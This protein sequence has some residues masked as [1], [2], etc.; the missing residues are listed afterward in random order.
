MNLVAR[1]QPNFLVILTDDLGF[2]DLGCYGS[3]IETPHLDKLA[4]NGV[5][6]SQFYNTAKCHSSR[7]ALLSGRWCAQAGDI[8]LNRAVTIAEVLK[9]NNYFTAMSGKWHLAGKPEDFGFQHYY[10]HLSGSSDYFKGNNTFR[11]NAK[12]W[13]IPKKGFYTTIYKVNY[14]L[15]FLQEARKEKKPWFLYLAFNAPHGPLQPLKEDY[16]KYLKRYDEGWD[17]IRDRRMAKQKKLKLFAKSLEPSARPSH[18][19]SWVDMNTLEKK[20]EKMRMA[21]Y[22]GM[23]DRVDQELGRVF[24]DLE[25]KKELQNTVIIFMSDNGACPYDRRPPE[26]DSVPYDGTRWSDS[27]GW[28]WAR[29]APFRFYK[30]NQFEGG[31]SSPCIVHWPAGLK[32]QQGS[33]NHTPTHLVD[34][35]PTIADIAGVNI[36]SEWPGRDVSPLAGVSLKPVLE[37]K[38]L[39]RR[40][41]IHLKF[42]KDVGLR[43]GDWKLV[44]FQGQSWELYNIKEDRTELKNLSAQYPERVQAMADMWIQMSEKDLK[45]TNFVRPAI[46]GEKIPKT[47]RGWT[48][49][50]KSSAKKSSQ[51]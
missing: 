20:W 24:K 26:P 31:I 44:S 22:A 6:F 50:K 45:I 27:T 5:R 49:G 37:A 47:N 2:S 36:P 3:E 10:G 14:A 40:P 46:Q 7:V 42:G 39:S 33:V 35:L 34:I 41:A 12:P 19:K 43:D 29:N 15:K 8:K 23:I 11:L 16:E 51:K 21:A 32:L 9:A 4:K 18:V 30:R 25:E 48:G 13:P 17:I 1:E 28:T 38:P